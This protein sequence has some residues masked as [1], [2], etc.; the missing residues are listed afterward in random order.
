MTVKD[1]IL[2]LCEFD[3]ELEIRVDGDL[4]QYPSSVEIN[5]RYSLLDDEIFEVVVIS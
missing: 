3:P 2:K 1:L 4:T 5:E